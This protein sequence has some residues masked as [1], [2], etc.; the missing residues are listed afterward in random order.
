MLAKDNK[1]KGEIFVLG[2]FSTMSHCQQDETLW[3][4]EVSRFTHSKAFKTRMGTSF[5]IRM[6]A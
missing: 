3:F 6:L 5:I 2:S 1:V 4:I